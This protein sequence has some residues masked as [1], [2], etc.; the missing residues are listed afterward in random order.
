MALTGDQGRLDLY[1]A[2][3]AALI[4]YATPILGERS[5]AEDVVQEA[6]L[7]FVPRGAA[8]NEN[9]GGK[10]VAQP[11]SYLYRI[12][13]NLAFDVV[14]R[15]RNEARLNEEA[16]WWMLPAEAR[17]PERELI[18][19]QNLE[20]VEA[21]LAALPMQARLAVEMNRFGGYTLHEISAR[22]GVS[23]PTV[24][25]MVRDGLLK[26]AMAMATDA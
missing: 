20:R 24:H 23:P 9:G 17:P 2:H 22:I 15:R 8:A 3:R 6:F 12:V 7:R 14:R 13:R 5:R 4:D 26:I 19:Q 11:L 10:G 18:H 1:L 21:V 25:R 16:E